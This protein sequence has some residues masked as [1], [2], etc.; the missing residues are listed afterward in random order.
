MAHDIIPVPPGSLYPVRPSEE[1]VGWKATRQFLFVIFKWQRVILS[2]FLVFTVAALAA[3]YLKPEVR[4]A[5]AKIMLKGDRTPLMISGLQ[6]LSSRFAFSPQIMQTEIEMLRGREVLA[7]VA[8]RLLAGKGRLEKDLKDSEIDGMVGALSASTVASAIPDTSIIQVTHFAQ[9]SEDAERNLR[10]I[11]EQYL[12]RQAEIQSGSAK[13]L[14]FYEQEKDRVG[15]QLTQA[16]EQLNDWQEKN[17]T[18]AI[19]KQ[20]NDQ[21]GI[22]TDWEKVLGQVE[23][24]IEPSKSRIAFLNS[25][26]SAIPERMVMS[27]E[28]VRNPAATKLQTDL[29]TAEV[30]LKDLL[31]R[32]TEKDRR[33]QEKKEQIA[34]LKKELAE[35]DKEEVIGKE[36]TGLNPIREGLMKE[37][38]TTQ[39]LLTSLLSK[40]ETLRKQIRDVTAI[41]PS[42]RD[43]QL[44][45]ERRARTVGL[46]KDAYQ[47]Y[48]KKLEE[49]RIATGLGKEQLGHIAVIESAHAVQFT[50]DFQKRAGL[51][52]LAGFVGLAL[53]MAIA[54]GFEFFNNSLRTQE[55]AEHYLGLPVLAAIPDL[56][57][58]PVALL[59]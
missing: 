56:R 18:L 24:E 31:M 5:T 34:M 37:L 42:L 45:I 23:A 55:D 43:K 28:Q 26:L 15:S 8:K 25:Q 40:R 13:L 12:E 52:L 20:I 48:G 22:L 14:K 30:A 2:F 38:A 53:G 54:F 59:S 21:L 47:L 58:R 57:D 9:T 4:A 35:A 19:D 10:L 39:G 29:V 3:M 16:E 17:Q 49:A 32:Y 27:R 41:L 51:V 33:V 11:T 46:H 50:G 44:E 7:P 6:T 36:I 1:S